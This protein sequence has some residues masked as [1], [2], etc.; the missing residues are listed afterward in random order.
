M[1]T[2]I[3]SA[4]Y[5]ASHVLSTTPNTLASLCAYSSLGSAQWI[6]LHDAIAL[7]ANNAIPVLSLKCAT[8]ANLVLNFSP[9]LSFK[10]GIVVCNSTTGPALTVGAAD[11]YFTAQIA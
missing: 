7:P 5:E 2:T 6:Q 8:V 4:A 3:N 1:S 10:T 11:T 9:P